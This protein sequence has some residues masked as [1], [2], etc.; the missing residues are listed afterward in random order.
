MLNYEVHQQFVILVDAKKM[1]EKHNKTVITIKQKSS[2]LEHFKSGHLQQNQPNI[3]NRNMKH[4]MKNNK[5]TLAKFVRNLT[6]VLN[7]PTIRLGKCLD[8]KR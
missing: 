6:V 7:L 5:M 2:E 4:D 3:Q 1:A 8:M